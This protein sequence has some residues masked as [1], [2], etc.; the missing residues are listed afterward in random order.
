MKRSILSIMILAAFLLFSCS[1]DSSTSP[2]EKTPEQPQVAQATAP[3]NA[4]VEVS[5]QVN[6]YNGFFV[7]WL[8]WVDQLM[9]QG[10]GEHSGNTWT[11]TQ[12][13]DGFT[14]TI[15]CISNADGSV[16]WQ[17]WFDGTNG[18]VTFDNW[19]VMEGYVS[20][21]KKSGQWTVYEAGTENPIITA[22]WVIDE[23]GNISVNYVIGEIE[24]DFV[25]NVDGSGS[26]IIWYDKENEKKEFEAVWLADG[27]GCWKMYDEEGNETGSGTW[28]A[29]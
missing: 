23:V 27:S 21:D 25:N 4:P 29:S 16:T 5:S 10:G 3:A 8:S 22:S 1:E 28:E 24:C 19:L 11:W 26:I 6:V 7:S 14:V 9:G 20:A 2:D 18:E 12:T 15:K 17:L 13:N